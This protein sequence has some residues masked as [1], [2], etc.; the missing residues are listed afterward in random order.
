MVTRVETQFNGRPLSI[1]TGRIARQA[2]GAVIVQQGH[3]VVLGTVV[4][5]REKREGTDFFPLSVDYRE[6]LTSVGKFPGGFLKREGRPTEK[7]ILTM[8]CIDRPLRP[9]FP[10]DYYNEVQICVQVMSADPQEDPDVLGIIAASACLSVSDVPFNGPV[11]AVR[12]CH[13]DGELKINPTAT[14]REKALFTFVV[15]GTREKLIMIEGEAKEASNEDVDAALTFAHKEL[16]SLIDLQQELRE[17]CAVQTREYTP[18]VASDAVIQAAETFAQRVQDAL[19]ITQK[20][21]RNTTL[22]TLQEEFTALFEDNEEEEPVAIANAFD[23]IVSR[24]M[25]TR[26][27]KENKRCDG[28]SLDELRQITCEVGIFP[29]IHGSAL[30]TRGETQSIA[31]TTLGTTDDAQRMELLSGEEKRK[32]MLHYTFPP[33]S[34]GE[35][36]MIRGPGRREIGHGN[37]AERSLRPVVPTDFQYTI[38]LTSDITESNGSSSM[39][40]VCGGTLA[41]MDAGVPI[42]A[43]V[44]GISI[45]LIQEGDTQTLLTDI[46]GDEDHHGDM[47]FKVAG[48]RKGI[49]GVQVDLK[50]D[51]LRPQDILP[52]L[53]RAAE[54]RCAILDTMEATLPAPR[55]ELSPYAPKML[56]TRIPVDKIGALIGPGG[57]NVK[58]IQ[59]ECK[60]TIA[61]EEDGT[62]QIAADDDATAQMALERVQLV[63][64][65]VEEGKE[66]NGKVVKIM[67]FGAFVNILPGTDG[68]VH[69]SEICDKRVDAVES[70]LHEGDAV[71][72]LVKEIDDRDRVNLTMKGLPQSEEITARIAENTGGDSQ[73][74]ERSRPPRNDRR[75]P[76]N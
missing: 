64:A 33:Y 30:F 51:G 54:A 23:D 39:A 35:A 45:G 37:L 61:I 14:E 55:T 18:V 15:V 50:I 27:L 52:I 21:E 44:A 28:R 68:M 41:L 31:I 26:I 38:R 9:L 32:F 8:R 57:K 48:T 4:S 7:E 63:V 59:E 43:P 5:P 47:D 40:S 73:R 76:R 16:Q 70:I 58:A 46:L 56:V 29:R 1:E 72:V 17:K 42:S 71:R 60:C 24:E 12:V 74:G 49:T 67:A 75:P 3:A 62:V 22:K 34:V 2:D 19:R 20:S 65:E 53:T 69:I 6:R 13:I 66:Y 36:R 11:G 10:K 25:R